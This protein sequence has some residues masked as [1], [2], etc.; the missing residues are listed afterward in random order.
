MKNNKKDIARK[1][2]NSFRQ[3]ENLINSKSME[4]SRTKDLVN[5]FEVKLREDK[6]RSKAKAEMFNDKKGQEK[7]QMIK[8]IKL[9]KQRVEADKEKA[10]YDNFP[11]NV[12][13]QF[14]SNEGAKLGSTMSI[15]T[16]TDKSLLNKILNKLKNT[17]DQHI[18][19][20][21]DNEISKTLRD[22]LLANLKLNKQKEFNSENVV[23]IIYHPENLYY[24]KPLTRGGAS[25]EGHTDSIL[26][27]QFSPCGKFLASGGGDMVL[28]IWDMDTSTLSHN[29]EGHSSWIMNVLWSPCGE[30]LAS[31]SLNGI[32]II[33]NGKKSDSKP[34]KYTSH[35]DCVTSLS[36]KPL[37]LEGDYCL[38]SSGKDGS[39][40]C[41][42]VLSNTTVFNIVCH[43]DSISKVIWSGENIIYTSSRDKSL[44]SWGDTGELIEVYNGH[45]HWINTMSINTEFVL[46]TGFYDYESKS[47]NTEYENKMAFLEGKN[48]N[49]K[50]QAALKR[51][52]NLKQKYNFESSFDRLVTGSDDFTMML[53][54]PKNSKK[55]IARLT[56]HNQ[57]VNHVVFSPNSLYIASASFDKS[58]KLWNASTGTFICNFYGHISAVYQLSW[59]ADSKFLVSASKDSTV[60]LWNIKSDKNNKSSRVTLPGH[61][62]EVYCIDWSPDGLSA[63]SGSKDKRVNTWKH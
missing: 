8:S 59:S 63:A 61:S 9:E 15:S 14:C 1:E 30:Y 60:K 36:W 22:T 28:R 35:K 6:N 38:L 23:K 27:V 18:M 43:S 39:I 41:Y 58:I 16:S 50:R 40:R 12:I 45:A 2:I 44:R 62:D 53:W 55:C 24:V 19:T 31:G 13:V 26:T 52:N 21:E 25:M 56:G 10:F 54:N 33:V 29:F 37:H 5:K 34:I 51:Y 3:K 46:R 7:L 20:V 57:L 11:K 4:R 17:E 48:L 32:V 49:E 47:E 42:S